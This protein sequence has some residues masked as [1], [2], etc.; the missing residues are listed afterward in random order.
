MFAERLNMLME[1]TG[2]TASFLG[3]ACATDPSHI[4]RLRRGSRPL[5]KKP[6]FLP[7]MKSFFARRVRTDYQKTILT[8]LMGLEKWPEDETQAAEII[9]LWLL[10]K[11]KSGDV[12]PI[13]RTI[14][15]TPT[16]P[17]KS[18][19]SSYSSWE[20]THP[21]NSYFGPEGKRAALSR[22]FSLIS[23]EATPQTMLLFSDEEMGWLYEDPDF[24]MFWAQE[25]V[26]ILST[27][28]RVRIIHATH[29]G[30]HEML[31]GVAKWMPLYMT[32]QVEP[33]Y[34]PKLR[35]D[36]FQRTLFIAPQTAA[37][38]STS[39][40]KKTAE[41]LHIFHE[42]PEAV[43]ALTK[44]YENLFALC[45]PLMQI[46]NKE[47]VVDFWD[48]YA[49]FLRTEGNMACLSSL[50][51]LPT[52]PEEVA[53]SLQA[54]SPQSCILEIRNKLAEALFEY[55]KKGRY[56]ELLADL[57]PNTTRGIPLPFAD[58]LGAPGFC[59][60]PEEYNAHRAHLSRLAGKNKH[61]RLHTVTDAPEN[62]SLYGKE[63]KG[64]LLCKNDLSS[65]IFAFDEPNM[66]CAFW[67]YL[68]RMANQLV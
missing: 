36:L 64:I 48:S 57:P 49:F 20:G 28:N 27:G 60:T 19:I 65:L 33:Y 54:R 5:P 31:E 44:E 51:L 1:L 58:L 35:D 3:K 10:G 17:K 6:T 45:R 23:K 16:L 25:C 59:Y 18:E 13:I 50:P 7:A 2:T 14:A 37:I 55:L 4:S 38:T 11:E 52:M 9:G 66:T 67:D 61:Y 62:L 39:V 43:K 63:D 46:V 12:R 41:M 34:Y 21:H 40:D 22:L 24:A 30:I 15:T 26:R 32:G 47:T 8:E 29:R 68:C 53:I 56:I 42:D